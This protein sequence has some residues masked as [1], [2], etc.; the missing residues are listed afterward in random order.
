MRPSGGGNPDD[1]SPDF[2]KTLILVCCLF[3]AALPP[4]QTADGTTNFIGTQLVPIA[5]GSFMMGQD[6][7]PLED[8]PGQ[9]RMKELSAVIHRMGFD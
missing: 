6:G 8:C 1:D 9:K 3:F 7:P 5:P 4:L 2:M